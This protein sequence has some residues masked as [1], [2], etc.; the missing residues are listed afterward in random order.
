M[1][2]STGDNVGQGVG[3]GKWIPLAAI[4][5][6]LQ[7][8]S[9]CQPLS[10]SNQTRVIRVSEY[11]YYSFRQRC[12]VAKGVSF[13]VWIQIRRHSKSHACYT[14]YVEESAI[15]NQYV[16]EILADFW[17][18]AC[19]QLHVRFLK[20]VFQHN[21]FWHSD[22]VQQTPAPRSSILLLQGVLQDCATVP[23]LVRFSYVNYYHGVR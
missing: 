23:Q 7:P 18:C 17:R 10:L 13:E 11:P 20:I 8:I 2:P 9:R 12:L 6:L 16:Q 4:F 1:D 19:F 15:C 3:D 21:H 5:Q 14:L 22:W